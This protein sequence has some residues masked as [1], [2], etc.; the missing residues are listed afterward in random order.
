MEQTEGSPSEDGTTVSPTAGNLGPP[1]SQSTTEDVAEGTAGTSV[2]EGSPGEAG[3]QCKAASEGAVSG[4]HPDDGNGS[5]ELTVDAQE[6]ASGKVGAKAELAEEEGGKEETTTASEGEAGKKEETTP[7]PSEVKGKEETMPTSEVQKADGK[8]ADLH[9]KDKSDV[10]DKV[11]PEA[12]EGV[13][14]EATVE[15]AETESQQKADVKDQANVELEAADGTETGSDAK[16]L[17]VS[18]DK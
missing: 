6:E 18:R 14:A 17:Q 5:N 3:Q 7:E 8:E 15:K 4:R 16:E 11:K 2:Q 13:E 1:G 9:A 12:K 10:N